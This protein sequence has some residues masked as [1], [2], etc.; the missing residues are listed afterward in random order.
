[1]QAHGGTVAQQPHH[2]LGHPAAVHLAEAVGEAVPAVEQEHDVRRPLPSG[3]VARSS[4]R[5]ANPPRRK[6]VL[7]LLDQGHEP[8][9]QPVGALDLGAGDH[10]TGV[11]QLAEPEQRAVAAVEAVEVQVL[12]RDLVG[13]RPGQSA[14]RGG[15][16]A[17]EAA[18][19]VEVAVAAE[20]EG[21]A[22][23]LLEGGQVLE[24]QAAAAGSTE[25]PRRRGAEPPAWAGPRGAPPRAA[26]RAR[27]VLRGDAQRA[28]GGA[29]R[30]HERR[31]V[32]VGLVGLLGPLLRPAPAPAATADQGTG[33][34]RGAGAARPP[35]RRRA[36]SADAAALERHQGS[37]P[38][39]G[40][41]PA[42]GPLVDAGGVGGV[43]DVAAVVLVGH[44]ERDPQVGVGA[45][46]RGHHA[47]GPLG[48]R[49]P[50]RCP[51]TG[52][53]GRCRPGPAK[54]GSSAASP[55]NSSMTRTSA[56]SPEAPGRVRCRAQ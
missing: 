32:G 4:A 8:R 25:A 24:H 38:R 42:R 43:H 28:A 35:C 14:Q 7:P 9:E 12:H 41:G 16:A 40:R 36:A 21:A 18:D 1:M 50:G 52:R 44:P 29:D 22:A 19:H 54:S 6:P 15:A 26:R 20:G 10:R 33:Q 13:Q 49:A 31:Q 34:A 37:R 39:C 55:A 11:R 56:G 45:D 27:A 17:A 2:L 48:R 53:A 51:A 5:S 30:V 3:R 46:L 23:L 47:A